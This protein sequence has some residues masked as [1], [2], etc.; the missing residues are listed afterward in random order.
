MRLLSWPVA[1]D[2]SRAVPCK[3]VHKWGCYAGRECTGAG[4]EKRPAVP[5]SSPCPPPD[6]SITDALALGD[7]L[8]SVLLY[9][10]AIGALTPD[11]LAKGALCCASVVD[12]SLGGPACRCLGCLTRHHLVLLGLICLQR[13]A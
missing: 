7:R 2:R 4:T 13:R 5:L 3:R 10:V 12:V 1:L 6:L 11:Q 9:H 8:T